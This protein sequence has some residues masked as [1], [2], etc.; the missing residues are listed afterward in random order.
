MERS[1]EIIS[2]ANRLVYDAE[3]SGMVVRLMGACAIMVHCTGNE[4]MYRGLKRQLSD[5]DL[6]T[7]TK[8]GRA[9]TKLFTG[10]GYRQLG[11]FPR[12][13]YYDPSNDMHVDV[14]FDRL[15]MCH[16]LPFSGRLEVDCPTIPLA[17]LLLEKIQIVNIAEKDVKDVMVLLREHAISNDDKEA[18]NSEVIADLL[19]NDWGFY[20]TTTRNLSL[21]KDSLPKFNSLAEED[22]LDIRQKIEKLVTQIEKREKTLRWKMRARVGPRAKWYTDVS[23]MGH[24]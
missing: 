18:V 14:F 1:K 13:V 23:D 20:Y 5:I 7:Y 19:S 16:T 11:V 17:E 4:G 15:E 22:R 2:H 10:L 9:L 3:K 24:A 6:M 12:H 8:F 21:I